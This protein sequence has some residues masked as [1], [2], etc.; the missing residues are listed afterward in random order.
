MRIFPA[1]QSRDEYLDTQIRRSERKFRYCKV[2]AVDV[3][4]YRHVL[5]HA[6]RTAH[7]GP[8]GPVLC[9]GTRNGREVDLFRLQWFGGP[10][11]GTVTRCLE[12]RTRSFTSWCPPLESVGRSD[13]RYLSET[14]V[15]GVEVNPW[16][17]R[18]DV[19]IGS[20]DEMPAEWVGRFAVGFS[21]AFDQSQN[22][23]RTATEWKRVIKPRGFLIFCFSH[24]KEPTLTDL[25]GGLCLTD[26]ESLF[27]GRLVYFVDRGS[28]NG[29][30]EVI[31]Q[32]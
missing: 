5:Q 25:V 1:A 21:N 27:G 19:W 7:P 22:P 23:E 13:F 29:Y 10:L 30:S 12:R 3:V 17:A 4:K 16:A 28:L 31:L 26:I 6:T 15:V 8:W 2:S 32:L 14:S 9:L 20:F 18:R 24:D 11:L